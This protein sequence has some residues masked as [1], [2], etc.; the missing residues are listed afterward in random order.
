MLFYIFKR[1]IYNGIINIDNLDANEI[2]ELLEACDELCFDELIEDLQNFLIKEEK[3]WIQENLFHA[4]KFSSQ[5]QSFNLLQDYCNKIICENPEVVLN[6]N[7]VAT[8]EK[9]MFVSIL[10]KDDLKMDEIDI[11]GIILVNGGQGKMKNW[12]KTF[13][14]MISKS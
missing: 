11:F 6:S 7:N 12:G 5:Y 14:K 13:Q 1:Y 10:K 3:E 4:H 9:S 2:L 8:I